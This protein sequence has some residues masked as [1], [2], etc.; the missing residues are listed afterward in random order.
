MA[1]VP[2]LLRTRMKKDERRAHIFKEA[3]GIIGEQGYHA[4][5]LNQ[6][7]KRC[8]LTNAGILYY[9]GSKEGLLIALL[10]DRDRQDEQAVSTVLNRF[11]TR[12]PVSLALCRA[13]LHAIVARNAEQPELV[14]LYTML[15][16][17]ALTTD[18]PAHHFFRNR[19]TATI[20]MFRQMVAGHVADAFSTARQIEAL[21]NGLEAQWLRQDCRFNL[22]AEWDK[23]A[24]LIIP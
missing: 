1:M 24:A 13:T 17:E 11:R 7:A 21:M 19:E 2:P 20:E 14:R 8:G 4:F 23:A 3:M 9:F 12:E 22:V 6:L 5:G 10:Q 18:H 16:A 15:R